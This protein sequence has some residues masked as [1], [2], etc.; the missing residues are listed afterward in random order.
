[1]ART[2]TLHRC[3]RCGATAPRWAGRCPTCE[4][5]GSLV[6]EVVTPHS[7]GHP[8]GK[9]PGH[10][11]DAPVAIGDLSEE[12][13]VPL[14]TGVDEL[15]RVLGGG[16]VPGSVTLLGGEPGI[17][18]STLLLQAM[19]SMAGRGARCLLICAEESA[20]QVRRRAERLGAVTPGLWL[21]AEADLPAIRAAAEQVRPDVVVIDSIQTIWDPEAE[22]APGS[23]TQVRACAHSLAS[24]AK[25]T[26]TV[27][28]LVGHVTKDGALAG[29]RALEHLVDTVLTFDGER[30]HALRLLRGVKH[31]FGSTGELGLF[32]MAESGLAGVADPSGLFLG[33]RRRGTPGSAVFAAM[34]GYRPLLVEV[35]ALVAPSAMTAPRRSASGFDAGR[36]GLLLAVLQRR[37]ELRLGSMEVYVSAVGGVRL[38]EPGA[39]LAVCL[40]LASAVID[41][42]LPHD[43]V[44]VGEVGLAGEVR[45]VSHMARRLGEASRLGFGRAI[46]P[47]SAPAGSGLRT[48]P[49]ATLADAIGATLGV[50]ATR[51]AGGSSWVSESLSERPARLGVVNGWGMREGESRPSSSRLTGLGADEFAD[52]SGSRHD[53]PRPATARGSRPDP[54]GQH[55]RSGYRG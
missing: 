49:V 5:W 54:P 9:A 8:G 39:D 40:A 24:Y 37:A 21:V 22:S 32:E 35:Q 51:V 17:G 42:P 1:M 43:L 28:V 14:P 50:G 30:H 27:V 18:K 46:V 25:A 12:G 6:E 23:V 53:R 3:R 41:R 34:E 26:G 48:T 16:L 19:A 45:Q 7:P 36:L 11:A 47:V 29:P 15:D 10:A 2:R 38:A 52:D 44:A 33:D 20:Q 4:E 13:G 31:R 55:G